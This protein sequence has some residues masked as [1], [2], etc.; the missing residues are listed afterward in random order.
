MGQRGR[1]LALL[2]LPQVA[3]RQSLYPCQGPLE[4]G[5]LELGQLELGQLERVSWRLG[6]L[7]AAGLKNTT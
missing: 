6:P 4:L 7:E 2:N 1:D 5:P 3:D